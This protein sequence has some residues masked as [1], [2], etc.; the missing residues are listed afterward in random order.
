MP[1][2]VREFILHE[3]TNQWQSR[4]F[5]K[6][7]DELPI[8][9]VVTVIDF[10]ENHSFLFQHEIQSLHWTPHQ[11]AILVMVLYRHAERHLDGVQSTVD[12]PAIIKEHRFFV[13]DDASKDTE[14]VKRAYELHHED[15]AQRNVTVTQEQIF[16]DGCSCQFKCAGS[17]F[18]E[19]HH[20]IKHG[21][22]VEHHFFCSGHGKGEHDGAGAIVKNAASIYNNTEEGKKQPITTA[23]QLVTWCSANLSHPKESSYASKHKRTA[24]SRRYFYHIPKPDQP[25]GVR[26]NEKTRATPLPGIRSTHSLIYPGDPGIVLTRQLSCFCRHC[27]SFNHSECLNASIVGQHTS[28]HVTALDAGTSKVALRDQQWLDEEYDEER[29][30]RECLHEFLQPPEG[31]NTRKGVQLPDPAGVRDKHSHF[32]VGVADDDQFKS[33]YS[34]YVVRCIKPAHLLEKTVQCPWDPTK[35]WKEGELVIEG[36][37]YEILHGKTQDERL[38]KYVADRPCYL[39]P[40]MIRYIHFS[41]KAAKEYCRGRQDNT[42]VYEIDARDH[43]AAMAAVM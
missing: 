38:Y 43:E 25:G 31:Y 17:A 23:Q 22:Y 27:F 33:E 41:M 11:A 4:Q 2:S 3:H 36:R 32:I 7:L 39:E 34:Y 5:R 14:W 30:T 29:P 40:S 20:K 28:H 26:H 10:S 24:L 13:S 42:W 6:L 15:L 9:H 16:S 21:V 37:Y 1:S 18:N 8:G 35:K 19:S 12:S